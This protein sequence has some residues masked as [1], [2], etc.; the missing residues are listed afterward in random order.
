M[1][2]HGVRTFTSLKIVY[3]VDNMYAD[4]RFQLL[5]LLCSSLRFNVVGFVEDE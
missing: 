5:F 4:Y 3:A 1:F 2:T